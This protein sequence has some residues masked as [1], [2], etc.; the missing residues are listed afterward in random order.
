MIL[1]KK[2]SFQFS[3]TICHRR[4]WARNSSLH[5]INSS[6]AVKPR[7]SGHISLFFWPLSKMKNELAP[8]IH[9]DRPSNN[10]FVAGENRRF[11]WIMINSQEIATSFWQWQN[12]PLLLKWLRIGRVEWGVNG[13]PNIGHAYSLAGLEIR[14]YPRLLFRPRLHSA[15]KSTPKVSSYRPQRA[16]RGELKKNGTHLA[17]WYCSREDVSPTRPPKLNHLLPLC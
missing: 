4:T 15:E 9:A 8:T 3:L 14:P 6:K 13:V 12:F 5:V 1:F 11:L 10:R 17:N 16:K 7:F 2:P